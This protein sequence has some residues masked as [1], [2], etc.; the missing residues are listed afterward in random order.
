METKNITKKAKATKAAPKTKAVETDP[1]ATTVEDAPV[2]KRVVKKAAAVV[3][4]EKKAVRKASSIETGD[5]FAEVAQAASPLKKRAAA[6]RKEVEKGAATA[7]KATKK[8]TPVAKKEMAAAPIEEI[9]APT[10]DV[11]A[12]IAATEPK[13]PVSPA[14]KALSEPALPELRRENRARLLMQTPTRLFFYWSVK[15]NPWALLRK[16]FGDDTGSYSLVLKLTNLTLDTE[17][18]HPVEAEGNWWFSVEPASE[19]EAEIG[20]Y[21]PNRPYFRIVYSNTVETPR[22]SPSPHAAADSDWTLTANKFAEVLDVAGFA[23][24]AFDVAMAGDDQTAAENATHIAFS[25]FVG[26]GEYA[27]DGIAAED[28]R[29]AMLAMAGGH[30]LEQLRWKVGPGLFAILQ[31]NARRLE[32][33][34]AMSALTEYFDIDETEFTEEQPGA[35]VFGASLVHFP[36]TLKT[37]TV[38]PKFSPVSSHSIR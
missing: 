23:Q 24:D 12:E 21:A 3:K 37:R 15:E 16:A 29:Y 20:F 33:H 38:S 26:S 7:K 32:P 28:I 9:K 8:S 30:T 11:T 5:P 22:R 14:F 17:E 36:R 6:A 18:V 34:K 19:Y 31:A 35:A 1:F 27:L 4:A 13:V 2:K 25:R 10:L